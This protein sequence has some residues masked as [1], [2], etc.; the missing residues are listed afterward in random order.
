MVRCAR[1]GLH[2]P[3]D[4]ALTDGTGRPFCCAEHRRLGPNNAAGD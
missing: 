3:V 2:L 1:C 4:E